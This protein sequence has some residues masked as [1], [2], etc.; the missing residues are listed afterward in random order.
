[1]STSKSSGGYRALEIILGIIALA[2]GILALI[3]PEGIVV[4][5]VVMFAIA[6]LIVGVL[7]LATAASSAL[8]TASRSTNAVIGILAIIVALIILFFPGLATATIVILLGIGLFI[9]A[10]GRIAVGGTGVNLSGGLRA[11]LIVMGI[12]IAIFAIIIIFFPIIGV[13]T[14]AFFVS[15]VFLLIGIESLASGIMGVPL[16]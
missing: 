9:Y 5:I 10:I 1:M 11:L 16:I 15:I 12:L 3:Y 13:Y 14:W 8:T 6:L 7:R 2:V 4:T